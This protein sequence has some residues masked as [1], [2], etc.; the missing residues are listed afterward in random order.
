MKVSE[1]AA[2]LE[3]PASAVLEQCQRFGIDASWAGAELNGTDI[4]ILRS[5]LAGA[6]HLDLTPA[7][8]P[9]ETAA[10]GS[11][12]DPDA[13]P[14]DAADVAPDAAAPSDA[15]APDA[16]ADPPEPAKAA[17]LPPTAVG[18]MP[19]LIDEVTPEPEPEMPSSRGPGFQAAGKAGEGIG[20]NETR[21]IPPR[22]PPSKKR[23]DR[24][25]RNSVIALVLAIG[26]YAATNFVKIAS[27]IAGLWLFAAICLIVAI[28]D[29]VRGRRHV[30]THPE[31]QWGLWMASITLVI[32]IAGVIG[33][34]LSVVTVVQDKSAAD[35]PLNLGDLAAVKSA[36]WG[37]Q[38]TMRIKQDG[39]GQP[40]REEGTCWTT[41]EHQTRARQRVEI[42]GDNSKIDCFQKHGVEVAAVF[43]PDRDADSAYPG[44]KGLLTE[45]Q[46]RCATVVAK[47]Q[48]KDASATL[49]VEYPTDQ[50][51]HNGDHDVACLLITSPREGT[52]AS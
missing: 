10:A 47:A 35:A 22:E 46:R 49:R 7:D 34:T 13:M 3:V 11:E 42:D 32:A 5:E 48:K 52:L 33:L 36:R 17:P 12:A 23:L 2:E 27:V 14:G 26:A 4:V 45:A 19:D 40:A 21:S 28:V 25:A 29:A 30:Q 20:A 18:S 24:Q 16:P 38:R 39:W 1:L 6:E 37:Y 50:G 43:A 41:G 15:A 8:P 44:V 9:S 31:R 51:W